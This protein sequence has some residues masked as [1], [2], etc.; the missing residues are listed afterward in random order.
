MKAFG[1]VWSCLFLSYFSSAGTISLTADTSPP[2]PNEEITVWIHTDEPLLFMQL[3]VYVNG[4]A[5]ITSAMSETDCNE[6]GWENGWGFDPI[7]DEPNG[8]VSIGGINWAADVNDIVGY[9]K[10]RYHS[11]H[12][13]VY[14]DQENSMAGNWGSNFTFSTEAIQFGEIELPPLQEPNEPTPVLIQCP[15]GSGGPSRGESEDFSGWSEE[16]GRGMEELDSEPNIIEIDSD[17]TTNQ[18]WTSDNVYY[19]T[20]ES[21]NVRALLVIE[22]NTLVIFGY[23]CAMFVNDGGTLI[24]KGTPNEPII[25]TPDY[26][27]FSYPDYIGYYWQALDSEGPYYYSPLYIEETA[28]PATTIRYCLIEGAVGGIVTDN[29]RLTNPI[30]NNYLFGNVYGIFEFGPKMTDIRNNLCFYND[31]AGIEAYLAPEP[32]DVPDTEYPF[33]I[34]QNTC[35]T[36]QYCGITIHGT[37]DSNEVPEVRLLNNIVSESYWYGLNIGGGPMWLLIVNTGYYD[38]TANTNDEFDEYNPVIAEEFPFTSGIGE[39][40]YYHHYLDPNGPFVDAGIKYIE[41]TPYIGMTTNVNSLP[42]KDFVDLG[43]H[44][45]D[46]DYTGVEGV[47]GTGIDDLITLANYWLTYT[48]YDPNSPNYQDPNIV[49]PNTI[50]YGG[51]WNDDGFVDFTDF[52]LMAQTWNAAPVMPD[53]QPVI[54]GDPNNGWIELSV[55]GYTSATQDVFAFLNGHYVGKIP[56]LNNNAPLDV[57]VSESGNTPQQLKLIAIDCDDHIT[58]FG[59]TNIT[60]TSPL[61][62]CI[63]PRTYEP[64]EP[65]PFVAFNTGAGNATVEVYADGQQCVWSQNFTGNTIT[66]P[67]PVNIVANYDIENIQFSSSSGANVSKT[68]SANPPALSPP[69]PNVKALVVTPYRFLRLKDWGTIK[70]V[71][72][73]FEDRGVKY[74]SLTGG[75]ATYANIAKY[76]P[77]LKYLYIDSHGNSAVQDGMNGVLRTL[78]ALSDVDCVSAKASD[79]VGTPPTWCKDPLPGRKEQ[80]LKSFVTMGFTDLRFFY[81]DSCLGAHLTI[82]PGTGLLMW[83]GS[84]Q[85]SLFDFVHNDM[86]V[87]CGLTNTSQSRFY[88]GWFCESW[89]RIYPFETSFQQFSRNEW[90]ALGEGEELY[91]ALSEAIYQQDHF[92][93]DDPVQNYRIKGQGDMQNFRIRSNP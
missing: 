25:C 22:P 41:Q 86:S 26:M 28:S 88:Q 40:P 39:K 52:A 12:V 81:N 62:Y 5:T 43:F 13:A 6:F 64:N 77:Q 68:T 23:D 48:P 33:L 54:T 11:G 83:G 42:D 87:A 14:I 1:V 85:Q 63:L 36:Y 27:Y 9:F 92:G 24:A 53:L 89:S 10:F 32:I 70:A 7:I 58:C 61:S 59:L 2:D 18:I 4:D 76:A 46:W 69:D 50:S 93:P 49:D 20:A 80:T 60:Y 55:S 67:I 73:A 82:D 79:F 72:N 56:G 74:L 29:I 3:G 84:G 30:E 51:D 45:M 78:I 15:L 8:W 35:D 91:W 57:D 71:K 21:V 90:E 31:E 34:E 75:A 44:H 17:I 16:F 19:I 38:N 66:G 65:I 37:A 47:S